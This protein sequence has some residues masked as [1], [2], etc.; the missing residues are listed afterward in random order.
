MH[1]VATGQ[2]TGRAPSLTGAIVRDGELIWSGARGRVGAAGPTL[3]TQYRIGSLTKTFTAVLVMRLRDEGLLALEDR[4]GDHLSDLALGDITVAQLLSHT[5]G[6]AGETP[7]PWWERSAGELRPH[8][9][10]VLGDGAISVPGRHFHY[11]NSG[12]AIL[13]G[14]AAQLRGR[15]WLQAVREEILTPG[16]MTRTSA[17]PEAPHALGWAVHP[18]ADVL[19]PEPAPD[20]GHMA[21][22]GQ[23]W[24]TLTDLARY[25]SVLLG[26]RPDILARDTAVEMRRPVSPPTDRTW[27]EGQGLGL[28]LARVHGRK[29]FGHLGTMP[30]F[31][32]ACWINADERIAG[33]AFANA[34]AS[35]E[36]ISAVAADL[37]EIVASAHPRLPDE[38][39]PVPIHHDLLDLLGIWYWGASPTVLRLGAD[40][41]LA[42]GG[43]EA[44]A[45]GTRFRPRPDGTWVGLDG[46]FRH[47]TLRIGRG[48]DGL[49]THLDIG[50]FVF[51]RR[52]YDPAASIPGGLDPAGWR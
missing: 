29:L 50:S 33:I 27:H 15:P 24:S 35:P 52:P 19:L 2:V 13:G 41:E 5:G 8:L 14:L 39:T 16:G 42:L 28:Q 25:S 11:S 43:F 1:R 49:A 34:T 47:E 21:P 4:V 48:G 12:F 37:I 40:R 45:T 7:P 23:L 3:D 38:W 17:M 26:D 30:G 10:D 31:N 51:T 22:A 46:D 18:W 9:A 44:D 20:T 36:N 6:L 32:C